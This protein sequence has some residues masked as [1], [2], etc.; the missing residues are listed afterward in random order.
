MRYRLYGKDAVTEREY[1]KLIELGIVKETEHANRIKVKKRVK[2]KRHT[3]GGKEE[4]YSADMS[5]SDEDCYEVKPTY[6]DNE[7]GDPA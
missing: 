4:E 5:G 1:S 2:K 7:D 6:R 3:E